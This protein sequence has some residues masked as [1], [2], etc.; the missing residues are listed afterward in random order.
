LFADQQAA[1]RC[2]LRL[3]AERQLWPAFRD[4]L[5]HLLAA[6]PGAGSPDQVLLNFERFVTSAKNAPELFNHLIN[7][8][9]LIESL[10]T[11]FDSS[12]FL[13]EILLINPNF[14]ELLADHRQL[15]QP[16]DGGKFFS[17][18]L[19][20]TTAT[21]SLS[22]KL[23][24]LRRYQHRELLRIGACDVLDLYDLP[25]VTQQLSDLADGLIRAC[26]GYLSEELKLSLDGFVVIAVGK[27]GGKELNYSSDIDLLF[28]GRQDTEKFRRLG[29][30][31]IEALSKVTS[32]GFLYRVDMRLRPWGKVGALVLSKWLSGLCQEPRPDLEKQSLLKKRIV[33]GDE[34]SNEFLS[35]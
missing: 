13:T 15:A 18:A 8:P 24:A 10:V 22:E 31:L 23:D 6:L 7:N 32:E 25:S 9:R 27:L 19:A 35:G 21:Q 4:I 20:S 12:Q 17:E 3:A 29:E 14:V 1:G 5:A 16:K 2:L 34:S 33:A 26:I 30:A 28:L 11:L